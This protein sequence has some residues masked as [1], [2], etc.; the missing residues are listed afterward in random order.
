VSLATIPYYEQNLKIAIETLSNNIPQSAHTAVHANN[1]ADSAHKVDANTAWSSFITVL[2][3]LHRFRKF[4]Q[5]FLGF[6]RPLLQREIKKVLTI[7]DRKKKKFILSIF[8]SS[9]KKFHEIL[10]RG[11]ITCQA[12]PKGIPHVTPLKKSHM[13]YP[14]RNP[15]MSSIRKSQARWPRGRDAGFVIRR[16]QVQIQPLVILLL[17]SEWR[18][19]LDSERLCNQAPS[20]YCGA[21]KH[22]A[23]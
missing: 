16:L 2:I 4:G 23:S 13:S 22:G 3:C 11:N 21:S 8:S 9:N 17:P 15:R 10:I 6:Q 12:L 18:S 7:F 20:V 14:L 19:K 1:T 5:V